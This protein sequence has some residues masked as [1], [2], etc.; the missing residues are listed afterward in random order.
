MG[1]GN[2][3][4]LVEIVEGSYLYSTVLS[5]YQGS[6]PDS[7]ERSAVKERKMVKRYLTIFLITYLLINLSALSY[8]ED[9]DK[10][11]SEKLEKG[12]M[13]LII[14]EEREEKPL[15]EKMSPQTPSG[16]DK[17]ITPSKERDREVFNPS[18]SI[19]SP[20]QDAPGILASAQILSPGRRSI[21][22]GE[23]V[24]FRLQS[25]QK[26]ASWELRVVDS[27]A[28]EIAVFNG[29]GQ[30]PEYVSMKSTKENGK[31]QFKVGEPYSSVFI[32]T[33]YQGNQHHF[34][35][36]A[37]SFESLIYEVKEGKL[38]SLSNDSLFERD[39]NILSSEGKEILLEVAS[40]IKRHL[41]HPIELKML[42]PDQSSGEQQMKELSSYLSKQL[43]LPENAISTKLV[44]DKEVVYPTVDFSILNK[45][46]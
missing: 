16:I 31:V 9:V 10:I 8:C 11:G 2:I 27:T 29:K 21:P 25:D 15:L 41:R 44:V 46:D 32:L 6:R 45:I 40:V 4:I 36:K 28:K 12:K 42:T 17:I 13:E 3:H 20:E 39:K 24:R 34:L 35:G 18:P 1:R 5:R 19:H 23:V 38:I 43:I 33:D 26:I 7:S 14:E 37:F 30:P 22:S